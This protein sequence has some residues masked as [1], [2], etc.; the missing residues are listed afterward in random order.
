MSRLYTAYI[1]GCI[2]RF[3]NTRFTIV[4]KYS[5]N[6]RFYA[7]RKHDADIIMTLITDTKQGPTFWKVSYLPVILVWYNKT[8][9]TKTYFLS[10]KQSQKQMH[11]WCP[12][13]ADIL[14]LSWT[15][16]LYGMIG[17]AAVVFIYIMLPETKGKSLQEIDKELSRNRYTWRVWPRHNGSYFTCAKPT[18]LCSHT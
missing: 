13:F 11:W 3:A 14:G 18:F 10:T 4:Q 6:C 1:Q 9:S 2:A 5:E 16:L 15:F 8:F 17:V 7:G 12:F